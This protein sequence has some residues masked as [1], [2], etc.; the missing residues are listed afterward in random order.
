MKKSLSII[1]PTI[2]QQDK[3]LIEFVDKLQVQLIMMKQEILEYFE[4]YEVII[5]ENELV[6]PWWNKWV[7]QATGD[8]ILIL[9]DDIIIQEQV[10]ETLSKLE[11]GQVY[12]PYFTRKEDFKKIYSYNWDNIVWFCFWMFKDDWKDIP[13][14]LKIYFGDNYIYHYMNKNIL[15]WW[16]I[17]HHESRSIFDPVRKEYIES[18]IKK[19]YEEWDKVKCLFAKSTN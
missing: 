13:S 17:H 14:E 4:S 6:N 11:K 19:D 8:I 3:D 2:H 7:K 5:I 18:L 15:W 1:I 12:C 10:F 9:N 16:Y